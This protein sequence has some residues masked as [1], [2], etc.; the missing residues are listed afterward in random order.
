LTGG[1]KIDCH[2][3]FQK[4]AGGAGGKGSCLNGVAG[5][6]GKASPL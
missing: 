5:G 2:M 1:F 6:L 3:C 4:G